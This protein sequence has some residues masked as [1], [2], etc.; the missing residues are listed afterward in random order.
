M[1]HRHSAR[2]TDGKSRMPQPTQHEQRSHLWCPRPAID[3]SICRRSV[4]CSKASPNPCQPGLGRHL[5]RPGL[6]GHTLYLNERLR[7]IAGFVRHSCRR[8]LA[9]CAPARGLTFIVTDWTTAIEQDRSFSREFRF[10]R[11]DGSVRWVM[12]EAFRFG[13]ATALPADMRAW[14]ATSPQD[15][16]QRTPYTP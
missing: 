7:R 16:W 13:S 5:S 15:S 12:A 11:P 1:N 8:M 3:I 2:E 9:E 4:F 10:Q 14:S 6:R